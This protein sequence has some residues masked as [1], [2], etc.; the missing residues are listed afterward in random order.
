MLRERE[1]APRAALLAQQAAELVPGGAAIVYVLNSG[2]PPAVPATW[3]AKATAGEISLDD[4]TV[5]ADSGTLGTLAQEQQPLLFS[6][7]EL[8]REDYAHLH[9][10]RTLVSLACVPIVVNDVL[11]GA[12]EV[13]SFEGTITSSDLPILVDLVEHAGPGLV[14]A[15]LYEDERNSL[16]ESV[17][18]LTQLYDLEKV[19]SS[20]LEMDE[21]QPLITSK[22][23]EVLDVQAVNLWL[24]KDENE[25]LLIRQSGNDPTASV[26]SSQRTGEGYIAE[27]SDSGEPLV[28][29]DEKDER[30]ARRNPSAVEGG[31]FSVI[32]CPLVAHEKQVGIIEAINKMDGSPFDEDDLFLLNSI[33]ETAAIALNNAGL[34]QAERK[35]EILQTLV[36][37]SGEITSTLNLDRVLQAVVNTPSAVIPYERASVALDERGR[38]RLKAVS[39]MEQINPGAREITQLE[40]VIPV[41]SGSS[42][43]IFIT[44]RGDENEARIDAPEEAMKAP[45]RKYFAES[46]MRAFYA[47]PLADDEGRLGL[48]L[49]ESS[50]PDFLSAAHLEMI[51]VLAGQ[52]TVA[53]RNASLYKEVPFIKLL[54]PILQK[55]TKFLALEKRRR[56]LFVAGAAAVALFLAIFP[57]PMRVDGTST[58]ASA[59]SVQVQPELD[60]VVRQVYVREGDHVQRGQVLADL[61]DWDYRSALAG[62]QAKYQTATMEMNRALAAN[63]GAEAGIQG[64]QARYWASEVERAR[65]RLERTHLRALLDGWVTTPHV[66][67][68][69][70]RHLV[71]GDTFAEVAD[72]SEARVDVAIDESEI[73][74]L[75]PGA[76][77]AIKVEGLPTQTFRGHVAVVSPKSQAEGD[78]RF[79]YAR[80]NVPNPDGRLRPGMQGRGKISVGWHPIGFVLF[81]SP[82]MWL[83]S[84]LWWWFGW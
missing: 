10:R 24:V 3:T 31:P 17:S 27:V 68:L 28:I 37:V 82:F 20:T 80:V 53:V 43:A 70:G 77:A 34:L 64:V 4:P 32:V 54:G 36:H 8:T 19:F 39:G 74:L 9:A 2:D 13:A 46:G 45:F 29:D 25:L 38:L 49:F 44:Q 73:S 40:A 33:S 12:L 59:R 1:S 30:L 35:V 62:A 57:I 72:S 51:R 76:A 7:N 14:S 56:A 81:R 61:E 78:A 63:D 50:D 15:I 48:L 18:R 6:G 79:F 71:A 65:E 84:K 23:R 67:D 16:L 21:L 11:I 69:T 60:G 75:R 5:P 55:K 47:L 58:V 83:Y 42:D 66:E 22:I 26:N 52:A 41:V